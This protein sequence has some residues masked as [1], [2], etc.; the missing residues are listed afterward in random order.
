MDAVITESLRE[1]V[2]IVGAIDNNQKGYSL[3]CQRFGSSNKFVKVTAKFL[4]EEN[5]FS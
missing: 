3:T 4:R 5:L 1:H 2:E